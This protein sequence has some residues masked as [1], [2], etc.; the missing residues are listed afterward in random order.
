[1][2]FLSNRE[3]ERTIFITIELRGSTGNL[4]KSSY[5]KVCK[6]ET[7][8]THTS[9]HSLFIMNDLRKDDVMVFR[10]GTHTLTIQ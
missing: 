7:L 4:D 6:E 5:F 1:M 10:I 3:M 2:C 9:K 8:I